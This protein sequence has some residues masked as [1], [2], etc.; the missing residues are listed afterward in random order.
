MI[1]TGYIYDPI[2][3]K[4]TFP[5]H[6]ESADRLK[7]ILNAIDEA[8][9]WASLRQ[10]PT[11]IATEEELS[12]IHPLEHQLRIRSVSEQGGGRIDADTYVTESS[13][14]AASMATGG[15]IDLTLEVVKGNLDNGFAI[16]RPPGHHA[17][18][19]RAMGFCL[20][21]NIAIA[22][23][24]A[25]MRGGLERVAVV[26]FDVHHGN[27]TQ[28]TLEDD[29]SVLFISSH[30]YPHYPGTGHAEE[31]GTGLGKGATVNFPLSVGVGDAGFKQLYTDILTPLLQRF[32]PQL[33]LVSAGY[34]AHWDDPLAQLGLTLNGIAWLSQ[35]LIEQ[36][37]ELCGGKIVFNLEGGYNLDALSHGVVNSLK[38]L[39]GRTDFIDPLGPSVWPEPDMTSY[40]A[41]LKMLHNL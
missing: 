26:D 13:F 22:A 30:Q 8:D 4:H 7:A 6:P 35:Y 12:T 29:P 9:L 20:F 5:G 1:R 31:L 38:A 17:E 18:R 14:D 37:D 19:N 15:L 10:I 27:G 39:L 33:I 32:Q 28:Y 24:V 23:K 34:D 16:A 2:F 36:A 40:V 11:R 25:Q 41:A 21:S 3:L